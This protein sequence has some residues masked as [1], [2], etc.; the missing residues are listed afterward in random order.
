MS[1]IQRRAQ[2]CYFP[3]QPHYTPEPVMPGSYV[4]IGGLAALAYLV[5]WML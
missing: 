1:T 3:R 2:F 5:S 4:I